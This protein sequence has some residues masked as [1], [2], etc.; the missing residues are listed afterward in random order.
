MVTSL[1]YDYD[2]DHGELWN[3]QKQAIIYYIPREKKGR[4]KGYIFNWRPISL[5]NVD[6][7][8]GSKVIVEILP[9]AIT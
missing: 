2:Y 6:V 8:L 4:D 7:K 3:T 1:S 9:C 5:I